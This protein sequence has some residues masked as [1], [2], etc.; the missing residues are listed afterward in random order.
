LDF[1]C[2]LLGEV[3][4]I[5][6]IGF[7]I[8]KNPQPLRGPNPSHLSPPDHPF[9]FTR[10]HRRTSTQRRP[11]RQA[12]QPTC[13]I[14]PSRETPTSGAQQSATTSPSFLPH[15]PSFLFP[16]LTRGAPPW[17]GMAVWPCPPSRMIPT[18]PDA[19]STV[20]PTYLAYLSTTVGTQP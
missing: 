17:K 2:I 15:F 20:H 4:T 19:K 16:A 11:K 5:K 14:L 1:I 9:L 18:R 12:A 10:L 8:R 13:L 3:Q 7:R 6:L